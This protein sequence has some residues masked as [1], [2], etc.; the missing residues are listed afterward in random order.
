M[1]VDG[2]Q[3]ALW[4]RGFGKEAT[5]PAG[6]DVGACGCCQDSGTP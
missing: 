5:H 4:V 2:V 1:G 3:R 6:A